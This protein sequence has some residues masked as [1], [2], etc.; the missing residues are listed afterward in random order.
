MMINDD[1]DNDDALQP[2]SRSGL[3][4]QIYEQKLPFSTITLI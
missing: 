2:D 3:F 4:W 1:D